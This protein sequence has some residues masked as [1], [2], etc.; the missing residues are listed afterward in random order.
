MTDRRFRFGVVAGEREPAAALAERARRLETQ[1]FSTVLF[2]DTAFTLDPALAAA[3]VATASRSLHCGPHVLSVANR[4][5]G[6]VAFQAATLATLS[7][8]RYEL[9][10]GTGRPGAAAEATALGVPFGSVG[11][12]IAQLRATIAAV[13]DRAPGTKVLV[14]AAGPRML[15]VAG[16]LAD[17][18]T[19]GLPPTAASDELELAVNTL[20]DAAGSRFDTIE[21]AQNLVV[22]GD[23]APP[24][25]LRHTGTDLAGL[26]AAGSVAELHGTPTEMADLLRRRRDRYEISYVSTSSLFAD[27]LAPVVELLAGT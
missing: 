21:L 6:L 24:A 14:A 9:G 18:V 4:T 20:R 12:R 19:F 3:V 10:L 25:I 17:A 5:P 1:G 11:Q 23:E 8:G 15:G 7:D 13:R 26:R 16:Q 27:R 22:V 2:P